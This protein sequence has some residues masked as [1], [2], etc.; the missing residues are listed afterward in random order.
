MFPSPSCA[1]SCL[2]SWLFKP[3]ITPTS[4]LTGSRVPACPSPASAPCPRRLRMLLGQ[5]LRASRVPLVLRYICFLSS[6]SNQSNCFL[7]AAIALHKT[8]KLH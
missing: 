2:C 4:A 1:A 3:E 6:S 8:I 7:A 5:P